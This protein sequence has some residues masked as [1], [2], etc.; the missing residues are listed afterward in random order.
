[1]TEQGIIWWCKVRTASWI[2]NNVHPNFVM[3]SATW[4]LVCSVLLSWW[5]NTSNSPPPQNKL[6]KISIQTSL[7]FN[8]AVRVHCCYARQEGNTTVQVQPLCSMSLSAASLFQLLQSILPI[9]TQ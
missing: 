3:A 8:I 7:A 2:G 5:S 4:K 9:V 6:T 1:V